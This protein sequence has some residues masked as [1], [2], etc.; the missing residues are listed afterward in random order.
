MLSVTLVNSNSG[1]VLINAVMLRHEASAADE[2]PAGGRQGYFVPQ[3][4]KTT[5][6]QYSIKNYISISMSQ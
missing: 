6:T 1:E 5:T 4:D 2:T 3:D